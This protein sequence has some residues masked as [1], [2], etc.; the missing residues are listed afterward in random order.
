MRL[1]LLFALALFSSARL[2]ADEVVSGCVWIRAENDGSGAGFLVDAKKKWVVTCRHVVGERNRVDVYFAWKRGGSLATEKAEYLANRD[3][4]RERKLLANGTVLRKSDEADLALIELDALPESVN[5]LSLASTEVR[6][7]DPLRVVGHRIDLETLFNITSGP[8]RQVGLL[9]NGY[10]WRGKKL[11]AN[12]DAIIGQLPI[13][14]GD[15]GGP[16]SNPRGEVVGMASALRRQTPSAA[17][18]ISAKEIR[19]FLLSGTGFQPVQEPVPRIKPG[20]TQKPAIGDTLMRSTVW[21]RPTATDVHLAGVLIEKNL[22]L[23]SARGLGNADRVG[24]AFPLRENDKWVGEREPYRDPVGLHLKGVWRAGTVLARDPARD[25]ALIRVDSSPDTSHPVSL[26]T[27]LLGVKVIFVA[28]LSW[29]AFGWPLTTGQWIAAALTTLGVLAMGATDIQPGRRAGLTTALALG[30]AFAFA[31]TDV[32]IQSWAAR[33]GVWNF[34]SLQF[35]ALALVS[36]AMLPCFGRASLRAPRAAWKW[37][38]LA[39][40]LS[41]LQSILITCAIGLW[42]DAAGVNV[43]YATRGL[44]SVALVWVVG[45]RFKNSERQAVG[46]RTMA[47]RLA[48]GLLILAAVVLTVNSTTPKLP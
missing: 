31:F 37:V 13:E 43:V 11:A 34:L 21:I 4:L 39:A 5:A 48:G 46:G 26:A 28:V 15:S 20:A 45:H 14:E 8:V 24:I 3:L 36:V 22:I 47:W 29:L 32:S 44:W 1:L 17:V 35:A 18:A 41:G 23:T 9:A 10:T 33:M 42:H 6:L 40:G 27:P 2:R 19:K 7:G 12:A 38:L 25:L 16:V 30:C